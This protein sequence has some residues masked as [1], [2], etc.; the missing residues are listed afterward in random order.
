MK[1]LNFCV[2]CYCLWIF[3]WAAVSPHV[4]DSTSSPLLPEENR[5]PSEG[6][7][8]GSSLVP[9]LR[10]FETNSVPIRSPVPEASE[11]TSS[12]VS[13]TDRSSFVSTFA[14]ESRAEPQTQKYKF[15]TPRQ[16]S[17]ALA[18]TE[19]TRL[20]CSI[21]LALLVV[22]S[23]IGFPILGSKIIRSII[24]FRPLYLVLLTNATLVFAQL[25]WIQGSSAKADRGENKTPAAG[26]NDLAEQLGKTLEI[27]LLV[28]KV[29]DAVFM[30][31]AVYAVIVVCGI[32]FAQRFR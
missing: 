1:K 10:E 9:P 32:S 11:L 2:V 15:F 31:C 25:L 12:L 3:C 18:A 30:T 8:G 19:R 26:G 16:I 27:G 17:S 29:V 14:T 23:D 20:F 4:E 7:L 22:L 5:S 21:A 24:S 6:D 13:S 28:Q